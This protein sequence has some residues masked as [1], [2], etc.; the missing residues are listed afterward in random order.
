MI[1]L[2]IHEGITI[3]NAAVKIFFII[4][5]FH[6]RIILSQKVFPDDRLKMSFLG[7]IVRK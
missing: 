3:I 2:K 1:F 7:L 4:H 6:C 5:A